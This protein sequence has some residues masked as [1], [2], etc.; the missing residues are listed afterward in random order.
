MSHVRQQIREAAI[1]A[2]TGLTSTADRVHGTRL[3]ALSADDLPALLITT[4][5]ETIEPVGIDQ[6]QWIERSLALRII[7]LV[8][9]TE[10]LDNALDT[11]A[12]E[13]E[14][15]MGAAAPLGDLAEVVG[16]ESIE[17]ELE[18][19]LDKPVGVIVLNY[20]IRYTTAANAP[21]ISL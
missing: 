17:T 20:R 9:Q 15:V 2:L 16:L 4:A 12:A 1:T 6:P 8:K 5:D 11:I 18:A 10:S 7:G 21:T 13:V 3:R 14:T 19:V